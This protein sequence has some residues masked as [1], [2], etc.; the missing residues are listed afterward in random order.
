[1][2]GGPVLCFDYITLGGHTNV[3]SS[4]RARSTPRTSR[5]TLRCGSGSRST[6][7]RWPS[8][9]SADPDSNRSCPAPRNWR[10]ASVPL[11][12][13]A[14]RRTWARARTWC[15]GHDSA[16][17]WDRISRQVHDLAPLM[18]QWRFAKIWSCFGRKFLCFLLPCRRT[19]ERFVGTLTFPDVGLGFFASTF[20][21]VWI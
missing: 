6:F 11:H 10:S 4:H 9:G 18:F 7:P 2:C 20:W 13:V 14:D 15:S 21:V 1:V 19:W 17:S 3:A 8:T 16:P 12:C 5:G